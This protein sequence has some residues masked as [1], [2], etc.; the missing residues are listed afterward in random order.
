MGKK[1]AVLE[2][3]LGRPLLVKGSLVFKEEEVRKR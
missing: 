2:G 1:T 3:P